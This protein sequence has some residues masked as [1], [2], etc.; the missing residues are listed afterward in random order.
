MSQFCSKAN[1]LTCRPSI[2]TKRGQDVGLEN[3]SRLW[4]F[5]GISISGSGFV[6]GN[7]FDF[8]AD[9]LRDY[10]SYGAV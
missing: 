6:G 4:H 2:W 1:I 8:D 10:R 7:A 3:F 9:F 5:C